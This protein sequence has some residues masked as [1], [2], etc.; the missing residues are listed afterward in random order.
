M[1]RLNVRGGDVR[2]GGSEFFKVEG[3]EERERERKRWEVKEEESGEREES[4]NGY[5]SQEEGKLV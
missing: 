4:G 5:G 2:K 3:V 1:S